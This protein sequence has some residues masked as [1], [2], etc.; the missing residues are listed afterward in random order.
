LGPTLVEQ[1]DV[2]ALI[3]IAVTIDVMSG[4]TDFVGDI[5]NPRTFII[6]PRT[7]TDPRRTNDNTTNIFART[8]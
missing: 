5:S 8:P 1:F 2:V 3:K 4:W 7:R 6:G